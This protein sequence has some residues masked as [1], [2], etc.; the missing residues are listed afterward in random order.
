MSKGKIINIEKKQDFITNDNKTLYVFELE[1]DNGDKGA[2]FKQK[3]NQFVEVGQHINYTI[4]DRGTIKIER[5]GG[6]V[7]KQS[8]GGFKKDDNVQKMIVRQSS[9]KASIDLICAGKIE[10]QDWKKSADSF[11]DWVYDKEE[12]TMPFETKA[13]F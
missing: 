2:I 5:E 12:T 4:T 7:P 11:V 6:F 10:P 1:L 9:L 13:P 3:D 8:G